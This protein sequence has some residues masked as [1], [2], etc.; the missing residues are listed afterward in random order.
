LPAMQCSPTVKAA[1]AAT[2]SLNFKN[3]GRCAC[4]LIPATYFEA[5]GWIKAVVALSGTFTRIS[6]R[7]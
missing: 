1:T 6:H 3:N 4:E 5:G 7:Q 2:H